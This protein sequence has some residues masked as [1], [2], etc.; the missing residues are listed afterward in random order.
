MV[1]RQNRVVRR[2]RD[3]DKPHVQ[4]VTTSQ[5]MRKQ[6]LYAS[7]IRSC[8][9]CGAPG[10]W[11]NTPGLNIGCYAPEKVTRLGEDFV[12]KICPC[13]GHDR[14]PIEYKGQIWSKEW[15]I[16]LWAIL[17]EMLRDLLIWRARQ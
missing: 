10:Y 6:S 14:D 13:C 4:H 8:P 3:M 11:H 17:R 16:S 12:G 2:V 5:T 1:S 15:R 9:N 7:V